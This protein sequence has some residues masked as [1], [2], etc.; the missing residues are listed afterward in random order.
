MVNLREHGNV[1]DLD[2]SQKNLPP[3]NLDKHK[4]LEIQKARL[5]EKAIKANPM[6]RRIEQEIDEEMMKE[7]PN[8][9]KLK[10]MFMVRSNNVTKAVTEPTSLKDSVFLPNLH[11]MS[12][13][14]KITEVEICKKF[15][16]VQ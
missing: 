15:S 6:L 7:T 4:A 1:Y 9:E 14:G 5:R 2:P 12:I 3:N 10:E 16:S 11:S 13:H 8:I